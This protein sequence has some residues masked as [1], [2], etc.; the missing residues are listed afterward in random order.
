M[1]DVK[2]GVSTNR[3]LDQHYTPMAHSLQFVSP[4]T[5]AGTTLGF[6]PGPRG[7]PSAGT[8]C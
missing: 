2:T 6:S 4:S 5:C 3:M 1:A 8:G 7:G